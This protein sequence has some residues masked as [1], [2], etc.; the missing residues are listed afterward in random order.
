[1]HFQ[2]LID[3]VPSSTTDAC[4]DV[5]ALCQCWSLAFAAAHVALRNAVI[6]S[7]SWRTAMNK[8]NLSNHAALVLIK[9]PS[10]TLIVVSMIN[11]TCFG[12]LVSSTVPHPLTLAQSSTSAAALL[13]VTAWTNSWNATPPVFVVTE[14][15]LC[16]LNTTAGAALLVLLLAVT[17]AACS[18]LWLVNHWCFTTSLI[19]YVQVLLKNLFKSLKLLD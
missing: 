9:S 2:P 7:W 1:M 3:T 17:T 18:V 6:T 11:K 15:V 4:A 8:T 12:W 19:A 5:A 13:A 14:F 16:H 10:N